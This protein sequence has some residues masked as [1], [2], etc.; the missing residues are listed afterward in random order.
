MPDFAL[1]NR[2]LMHILQGG[3]LKPA[4]MLGYY[5][6]NMLYTDPNTY[7]SQ[8]RVKGIV[9]SMISVTVGKQWVLDNTFSIDLYALAG[10]GV[11][12]FRKQ[13]NKLITDVGGFDPYSYNDILPYPNFGYTRFGR[14]D[15]GVAMGAGVKLGYLFNVKKKK[16]ASGMDKMRTRLNK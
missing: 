13:Q 8:T 4:I 7:V 1:S 6:R 12:N 3:Y 16:S 5:Q 11:D 9:T 10:L 15:A 14:G 2:K